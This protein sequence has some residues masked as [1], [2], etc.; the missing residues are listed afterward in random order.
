MGPPLVL[1]AI[2]LMDP[3]STSPRLAMPHANPTPNTRR[4][5]QA[6]AEHS[7]QNI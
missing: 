1:W 7:D 2:S 4:K 3:N 6:R 5:L